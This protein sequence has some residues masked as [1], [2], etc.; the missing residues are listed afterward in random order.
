M[1]SEIEKKGKNWFKSVL[2]NQ[3][4]VEK[5]P[6]D[7]QEL[8]TEFLFED[9]SKT[10]EESEQL[11]ADINKH[12]FTKDNQDK[13]VLDV[14]V[15]IENMLKERQLLS[16]KNRG[17]EE[18]LIATNETITRFKHDQIKKDQLLQEKHKEIRDLE[19]NLT[20]KQMSYDQLLEDYK[21]YQLTSNMEYEKI[22]NQL[23]IEISKYNKH[24]EESSKN[25]YQSMLKV[26][27]LEDTIRSLEIENQKYSEQYQKIANEKADLMNTIND[28]TER[29]SFSFSAKTSTSNPSQSE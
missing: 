13:I 24:S 15:S 10:M 21:E 8:V 27:E 12:F 23:E 11:N 3:H 25:Q 9:S 26:N 20:N 17:L 5:N 1:A 22:S 6:I 29:M 18:Q 14:M 2:S 7:K 28:F 4:P 19:N 16:F